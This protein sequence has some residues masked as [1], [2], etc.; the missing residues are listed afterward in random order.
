MLPIV[1][2]LIGLPESVSV[3]GEGGD[4]GEVLLSELL[5]TSILLFSSLKY[6][7]SLWL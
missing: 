4:S 3:C 1:C 5:G 6:M 7:I 2:R